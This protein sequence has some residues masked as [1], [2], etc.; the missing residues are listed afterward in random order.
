[1]NLYKSQRSR[2]SLRLTTP[3]YAHRKGVCYYV[4]TRDRVRLLIT[5]AAALVRRLGFYV[6]KLRLNQLLDPGCVNK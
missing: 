5:L 2:L 1:M 4:G 6:R 3:F